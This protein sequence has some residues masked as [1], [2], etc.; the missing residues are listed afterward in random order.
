M[1][2]NKLAYLVMLNA[3]LGLLLVIFIDYVTQAVND[4]E[5]TFVI[6][7]IFLVV[8]WLLFIE[9][10]RRVNL[11]QNNK[12]AASVKFAGYGSFAAAIAIGLFI[13]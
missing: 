9:L 8:G 11:F 5:N 2:I 13:I 3:F 12:M 6:G 4:M 10:F 7:G 1:K